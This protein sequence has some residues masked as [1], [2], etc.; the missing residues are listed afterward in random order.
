MNTQLANQ[1][2]DDAV[3]L[4]NLSAAYHARYGQDSSLRP[5]SPD[6]A[7]Q[8]YNES[9]AL[10]FR[11]VRLLDERAVENPH[12]LHGEWWVRDDVMDTAT[13]QQLL[14]EVSHLIARCTYFEVN[15]NRDEWCYAIH[16]AQNTIAGLLHPNS[17]QLASDP[18]IAFEEF[19]V[20]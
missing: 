12:R 1:I 15:D 8:L 6:D 2:M 14:Q 9:I 17:L 19:K 7:W 4:L 13:A 3:R 5:G 18:S 20:S 11:I 16:V 10:Q